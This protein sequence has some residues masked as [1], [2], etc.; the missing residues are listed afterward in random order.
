MRLNSRIIRRAAW[1]LARRAS[2]GIA[3][4]HAQI[5]I[6]GTIRADDARSSGILLL[7]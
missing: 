5:G 7:L 2:D 6:D 3:E 1:L 4:I